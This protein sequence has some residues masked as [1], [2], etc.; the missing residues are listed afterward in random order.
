MASPA[1]VMMGVTPGADG[2]GEAGTAGGVDWAVNSALEPTIAAAPASAPF[3]R[4][5]RRSSTFFGFFQSA[6][7]TLPVAGDDSRIVSVISQE[8][9]G[10]KRTARTRHARTS[11]VT[12]I[13]TYELVKNGG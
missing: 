6:M 3:C 9:V 8:A 10:A 5:S 13:S 7:F 2:A 12:N 1:A 4:N 11:L